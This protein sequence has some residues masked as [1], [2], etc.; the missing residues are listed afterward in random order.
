MITSFVLLVCDTR[1]LLYKYLCIPEFR[2]ETYPL[3]RLILCISSSHVSV[4]VF[5]QKFT[6]YFSYDTNYV[7]LK[8]VRSDQPSLRSHFMLERYFS[9]FYCILTSSL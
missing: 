6:D 2:Y 8:I 3:L 7:K 1:I 4:F 5:F 9:N